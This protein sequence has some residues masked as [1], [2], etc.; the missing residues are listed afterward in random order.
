MVHDKDFDALGLV[1]EE[2]TYSPKSTSANKKLINSMN[3]VQDMFFKG[4]E[5]PYTGKPVSLQTYQT[6][7]AIKAAFILVETEK[8]VI[9]SYNYV[10]GDFLDEMSRNI[11]S[12]L[13][14]LQYS[15]I[16]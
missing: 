5:D 14:N 9:N 3:A 1:G 2:G 12:E 16:R 7:T 10:I 11:S 15:I 6:A 4:I 8:A 13:R